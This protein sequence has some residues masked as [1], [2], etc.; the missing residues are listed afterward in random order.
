M[1]IT[2]LSV[3]GSSP[4]NED[5]AVRNE[6]IRLFGVIDGA[7][8]LVPF[9]G[10][11]GE[12]GGVLAARVIEEYLNRVGLDADTSAQGLL[13][14]LLEA[15]ELLQ[16]EM[17]LNGIALEQKEELW[18]ACAVIVHITDHW[19]DYAQAG[20]CMLIAFYED[21]TIRVVTHDQLEQI[22]QLTFDKWAEGIASGI[23]QR[24]EL[25]AYTKPQII[26]GRQLANT[27]GGNGVLNGDPALANY[28]EYGRISRVGV[29]AVLLVSDG[30]Y[31]PK[32]AGAVKTDGAVEL[33]LGVRDMGLKSYVDWLIDLEESD[34]E[35]VQYPRVKK[36]DDKTAI[37]IDLV[38]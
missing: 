35:C 19:I 21:N 22:D 14:L 28:A 26:R 4:W 24:D 23:V 8:S 33:A 34:P 30:L 10:R 25:W 12:T 15:N 36:S 2:S 7:T 31:K 27:P 38:E 20:D 9:I 6:D 32:A 1:K 16:K 3:K 18:N 37:Y 11:K 17:E 5:A 13:Q 29:K